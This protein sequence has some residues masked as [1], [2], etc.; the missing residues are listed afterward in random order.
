MTQ[1]AL[2]VS[3]VA[4]ATGMRETHIRRLCDAKKIP[5]QRAGGRRIFQQSDLPKIKAAAIAAGYLTE[6][7]SAG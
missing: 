4:I 1:A 7:K 5:H 6:P 2:T 3:D